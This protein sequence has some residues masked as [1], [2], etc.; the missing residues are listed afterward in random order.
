MHTLYTHYCR[1]S[2]ESKTESCIS[3]SI[4][5]HIV[6]QRLSSPYISLETVWHTTMY[7]DCMCPLQYYSCSDVRNNIILQNVKAVFL[8]VW[9]I[10]S[11]NRFA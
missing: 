10:D 8:V 2:T 7:N 3:G 6:M 5:H 4:N 1:R 9:V 11:Y